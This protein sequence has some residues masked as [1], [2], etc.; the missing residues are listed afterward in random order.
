MKKNTTLGNSIPK[1]FRFIAT[2][3][4]GVVQ[5]FG[6]FSHL[7]EPGLTFYVPIVQRVTTI[8]NRLQEDAFKF[9]VKT[10]DDTFLTIGLK[11]QYQIKPEDTAKA[12]FSLQNYTEQINSYI[13]NTVRSV[14][15]KM[16]LN[17]VFEAQNDI[18]EQ[19]AKELNERISSY[20]FTI[21]N[22]LVTNVTPVREVMDAMNKI[23]ASERL[24]VSAKNEA[25]ADYVKKVREAEADRDRKILQGQGISGQRLAILKGYEDSVNNMAQS[26]GLSPKDIINFVNRTQ[27]LDTMESIGRSSNAKTVFFGT[28][29]QTLTDFSKAREIL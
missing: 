4:T 20:G 1:M 22:T 23:K 17:Q 2:N 8:S 21:H 9:D 25:D 26:F 14:V 10:K 11:V 3:T 29:S 16:T 27:E 18:C 12:F 19:V 13:E 24:L 6:K 15:P 7:A 28:S 5:T